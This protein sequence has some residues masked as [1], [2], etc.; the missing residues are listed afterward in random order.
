MPTPIELLETLIGFDTTSAKSNMDLIDFVQ[1]YL[2][3]YGVDSTLV[4]NED[5]TKANLWATVGPK[6]PGGVCLSGHT[7]VVPV[8]GQPWDTD[9]FELI[10]KGSRYYGRGTCDMKAFPAVALSLLPEMLAKP[11]VRPIHFALSYDEEVG[12]LGAP[13]MIKEIGKSLPQPSVVI[14]GEPTDMKIVSAHKGMWFFR[15]VVTGKEAHS[16]QTHRGVSAVMTGARLIA[17]LDEMAKARKAAAD[18]ACKFVPPYTTIH[19]GQVEGGTASNIISRRCEFACDIRNLPD[20]FPE[21][22][23]RE[24]EAW[25]EAEILPEMKAID[26]NAGVTVT[27][28]NVVAGLKED[29]DSEAEQ[30]V[31]Q[32]TG[33]NDITYV[34]YGTEAGQ[35]QAAGMAV[36]VCG[37]GSIDQAHQANEFIEEAQIEQCEAMLRKLIA[38]CQA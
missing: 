15:V 23:Q 2:A 11:L 7:D 14:V 16:S 12:C 28:E 13:S 21:D 9:P 31:R 33:D 3:E 24:F 1:T 35:F 6:Q 32:I 29:L 37:P 22:I 36:V 10:K 38:R 8:V 26:P 17:K 4:H 30:L 20:D 19:V 18:P 5:Q 25:I 34:P 27:T